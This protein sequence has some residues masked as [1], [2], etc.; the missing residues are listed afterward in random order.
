MVYQSLGPCSGVKVRDVQCKKPRVA[1]FSV[2][3]KRPSSMIV[4]KPGGVDDDDELAWLG[5]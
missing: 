4:H 3:T 5:F 1:T 2:F